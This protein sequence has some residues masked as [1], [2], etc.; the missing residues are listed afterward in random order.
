MSRLPMR[1]ANLLLV[2]GIVAL[3][4]SGCGGGTASPSAGV[5]AA[6]SATAAS[7]SAIASTSP[8]ASPRPNGVFSTTGLMVVEQQ[9]EATST[10][11]ADGRV[12]VTGGEN[13]QEDEQLK[14]AEIYESATGLWS[15][16]GSMKNGRTWHTATLLKDGKVLV[17]GCGDADSAAELY[18]PGTGKFTSTGSMVSDSTCLSTATLLPDGR[19][20]LAGGFDFYKASKSAEIYD[21]ATGKFTAT[22]SLHT[23]R[24]NAQAVLLADGRVLIIGGCQAPYTRER[25][26]DLASAEIYD[27]A[28]GEFTPTGSMGT[29]RDNFSATALN[30]GTVLVAGGDTVKATGSK[31]LV[32]RAETQYAS[33]E[34]YDPATGKFRPTGSM[35]TQRGG[36]SDFY[37]IGEITPWTALYSGLLPDGRVLILGGDGLNDRHGTGEIYDPATGKFASA[38]SVPLLDPSPY[39]IPA[40][41]LKD[42]RVLIPGAPSLLYTP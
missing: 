13:Y 40:V 18:N 26:T 4:I 1:R 29:A 41:T 14:S 23:A 35:H 30:D 19:V 16:T 32:E 17:A 6:Q 24:E 20:L 25:E 15:M 9:I 22:G 37:A 36:N 12:L 11:L 10:L 28:T 5:S 2:S 39:L 8:S 42:G 38:P 27:P 33:A 21:P 3:S 34:I 7:P 31:S